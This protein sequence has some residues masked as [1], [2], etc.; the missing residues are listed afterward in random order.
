MGGALGAAVLPFAA[1]AQSWPTAGFTH[2]VASGDPDAASVL[3]WT[4]FVP[5]SGGAARLRYEVAADENFG[6][7]VARGEAEATPDGDHCVRARAAGLK[8]GAWHWFRF[9]GPD[10][11][12]SPMGR[13]KTLPEGSPESFTVGVFSCSNLPFGFFNAY[14]HAAA[15]DDIDLWL[16]VGDYFY[17]YARGT[18]PTAAQARPGRDIWPEHE[19]VKLADYR[20]RFATYRAD[21]DLQAIHARV[22]MLSAWDDHE[23]ANDAW[24]GGAQNH[25]EATEGPWLPRIKAASA[26]YYNWLPMNP[27]PWSEHRVGDLLDLFRLETRITGRD[28]QLDVAAALAGQADPARAI[29]AFRDG[30][31]MDPR[32]SVLGLRQEAWLADGLRRSADRATRWQFLMQQVLVGNS[33]TPREAA[34]WL[35]PNA[36]DILKQR[37]QGGLLAASAGVPQS[38]DSWS[39]YHAARARLLGAAEAA[40]AKLVVCAGDTHNAWAFEL[41]DPKRPVGVEFGTP[42]VSAPGFDAQPFTASPAEQARAIIAASPELKWADLSRRG[43]TTIRFTRDRVEAEF[44]LLQTVRERS[45]KL[46]EV[47]RVTSE[48]GSNRLVV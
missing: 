17:E 19:T 11:S 22:P 47:K 15:R 18:Y 12:L 24:S 5:P 39:G 16:H 32:R 9:R 30:P 46:A 45:V 40:R 48:W 43:Y 34:G 8:A 7:I 6:R 41:G 36:P 25:D 42:S 14:A 31:W 35:P 23:L 10:G 27:R 44:N 28:K 29:A 26:A 13:T 2:N 38:T 4:R 37:V 21:P 20:Q 1:R 33:F 3:L